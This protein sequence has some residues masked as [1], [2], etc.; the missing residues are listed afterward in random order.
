MALRWC[1]RG[2][3]RKT[4]KTPHRRQRG[5]TGRPRERAW[6]DFVAWC[7]ARRLQPLPAHPWTV[8]AYARW[9][10]S[11]NRHASVAQRVRA[12]ARAHLLAGAP[13]PDR[14][15][16]VVRTLLLIEVRARTRGL[17]AGLFA[18]TEPAGEAEPA[19]TVPSANSAPPARAAACARRPA[20]SP[21]ARSTPDEVSLR[22]A[23]P[24]TE[25]DKVACRATALTARAAR[26]PRV[27]TR[28]RYLT[29]C[30][31]PSSN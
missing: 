17:R 12:I 23:P 10:E 21:V 28:C 3:T 5:N 14:H 19:K 6:A 30:L 7:R 18:A 13:T 27:L 4:L 15:P 9:C 16:V 8:A 24:R 31:R 26:T 29:N 2:G 20:S 1:R 22:S 25:P 11:R